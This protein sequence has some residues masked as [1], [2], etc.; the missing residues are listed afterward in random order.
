M[1]SGPLEVRV[2]EPDEYPQWDAFVERSPQGTLF[3]SSLWASYVT[4]TTPLKHAVYGAFKGGELVGGSS[5]FYRRFGPLRLTVIPPLTR[6]TGL[7]VRDQSATPPMRRSTLEQQAFDALSSRLK[8]DFHRVLLSLQP[9]WT[10]IRPAQRSAWRQDCL[11]TYVS[12]LT[13]L[14]RLWQSIDGEARRQVAKAEKLGVSVRERSDVSAF[15]ALHADTFR[16]QGLTAPVGEA[17]IRA[18][19]D[20]LHR[21]DRCRLFFAEDRDGQ[22]HAAA[23]IIWDHRSAYYLMGASSHRMKSSGAFS[24]LMWKVLESLSGRVP[25]LDLFGANIASIAQFKKDFATRL[26][27]YH[28][29]RAHSLPLLGGLDALRLTVRRVRWKGWLPQARRSEG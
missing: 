27:L 12:D 26:E 15:H 9:S 10:D 28:D 24:L 13:D 17:G 19:H 2:L 6:Y 11:Y 25:K 16:R 5:V 1:A 3:S 20:H 14:E 7:L 23:F 18:L 29:L 22:L 21:A 4:Q 8:R